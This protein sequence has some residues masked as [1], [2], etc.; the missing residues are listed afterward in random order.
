MPATR[1]TS[2][3]TQHFM[4]AINS[5]RLYFQSLVCACQS[6]IDTSWPSDLYQSATD[7]H[8]PLIPDSRRIDLPPSN[9]QRSRIAVNGQY[10][11][12]GIR[13]T[14]SVHEIFG[15]SYM[16]TRHCVRRRFRLHAEVRCVGAHLPFWPLEPARVKPN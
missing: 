7:I 16:H 2:A 8:V 6:I 10:L 15:T 1:Y 9:E 13:C 11:F 4:A 5:G 3:P 14:P 12:Y